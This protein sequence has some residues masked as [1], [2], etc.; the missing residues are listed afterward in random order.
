MGAIPSHDI[1]SQYHGVDDV[2]WSPIR[3]ANVSHEPT[4][5]PLVYAGGKTWL[6]PIF[7]HFLASLSP[8]PIQLIDPFA[9][10]AIVPMTMVY[11]FE[12]ERAW[13]VEKNES[14]AAV[15]EAAMDYPGALRRAI[16]GFQMSEAEAT[17]V[18]RGQP[19]GVVDR[20][21]QAIVLSRVSWSG[22]QTRKQSWRRKLGKRIVDKG[23]S[24]WD[25]PRLCAIVAGMWHYRDRL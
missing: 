15:W 18:I 16:Q 7:R 17:R 20:A 22:G 3:P 11:G 5:G 6:M 2:P 4:R 25:V 1:G 9:G 14:V 12:V 13:M 8:R 21:L 10:G 19:E 23:A 24:H